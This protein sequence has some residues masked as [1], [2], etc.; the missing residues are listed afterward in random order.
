ML[1]RTDPATGK[2]VPQFAP[3]PSPGGKRTH[4]RTSFGL[5]VLALL[6]LGA[7]YGLFAWRAT[8]EVTVTRLALLGGVIASAENSTF[9]QYHRALK[10]L[11]QQLL[12]NKAWNRRAAGVW[13]A[14]FRRAYPEIVSIN[15]I[16]LDGQVVASTAVPSGRPLPDFHLIPRL[17]SGLKRDEFR[18]GLI[19]ARPL[20]GPLV[21]HWV[22]PLCYIVRTSSG[23]PCFALTTPL[24][25]R[26]HEVR[27]GRLQFSRTPLRGLRVS[28]VRDDGH[29]EERWPM[30][31]PLHLAFPDDGPAAENLIG[32][33]RAHRHIRHGAFQGR[34]DIGHGQVIGAYHRL[35]DYPLTVVVA[36]PLSE[37]GRLWWLRIRM[38][39]ALI[40]LML[41]TG[42]G[43]YL[44]ALA[45]EQTSESRQAQTMAR[46]A[47][48]AR[49]DSLTGLL[50]R[51]SLREALEG[52]HADS[53]K[54][55]LPYT[56]MLATVDRLKLINVGYGQGTG[57]QIL[58]QVADALRQMRGSVGLAGRWGGNEFLALLGGVDA[59]EACGAVEHLQRQV[60]VRN[61]QEVP[62]SYTVSIGLA[63]YPADGDQLS[64]LLTHADS[65][66]YHA[67]S[68][69]RGRA[70]ATGEEFPEIFLIG[71]H[72]EEALAQDRVRPVYQ[73]I[74]DLRDGR[75]V[76]EEALARLTQPDG[77]SMPAAQFIAAA[78]ALQIAHRID[79]TII[80]QVVQQCFACA[81]GTEKRTR[82]HFINLS[83]DLLRH[84]A[85]VSDLLETIKKGC[86]VCGRC[87]GRDRTLVSEI[88]ERELMDDLQ[89]ALRVLQ[90]LLDYG[91]RL[92]ID[93]FGSGYSSFLYLAD[94]P[95]SFLKIEMAL[96][97]RARHEPHILAMV[98]GLQ[99]IAKEL[100]LITIAEG[101]EDGETASLVR[102]IGIDWGQGYYFGYPQPKI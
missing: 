65:A 59:V 55:H 58:M 37:V 84:P 99:Y 12:R 102:E 83:A 6:V 63:S 94:L 87:T 100:N 79:Y 7:S 25:L 49:H 66:L 90:P 60:L 43:F 44:W 54:S 8:K 52:A 72:I 82:I 53:V 39:F 22:I 91:L 68:S 74:V 4:L 13:L 101:V 14:D 70:V 42:S 64:Q 29:F 38:P 23:K 2:P 32:F 20:Y 45:R 26:D 31:Q 61:A 5:S 86:S 95:V 1:D 57:D 97:R 34:Q 93:D 17:W 71:H 28:L 21:H 36:A 19:V 51:N 77:V 80:S 67:K 3:S 33:L 75:I 46:L 96:I 50:N 24:R 35:A 27:W 81:E 40:G 16:G 9:E 78:T 11:G 48:Q 76:A 41:V 18:S 92:A 85:L 73:P 56:L 10:L 62:V 88:T 47:Y 98:Q 15:V 69:G 30:A 89:E